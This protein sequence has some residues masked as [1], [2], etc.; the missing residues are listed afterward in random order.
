MDAK[1]TVWNGIFF[2]WIFFEGFA[3]NSSSFFSGLSFVAAGFSS[4]GSLR[5]PIVVP[6]EFGTDEAAQKPTQ[7]LELQGTFS[8]RLPERSA[9]ALLPQTRVPQGQKAGTHAGL[10]G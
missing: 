10:V 6:F 5:F 9:R 2:P 8:S 1:L 3:E 7:V 4:G